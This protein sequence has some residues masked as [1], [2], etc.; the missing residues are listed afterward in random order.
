MTNLRTKVASLP[1]KPIFQRLPGTWLLCM[2]PFAFL[3]PVHT[4]LAFGLYYFI[5]H[6][7][8]LTNNARSAYGMYVAYTNAKLYSVTDWLAKYTRDTGT[9][10]GHDTR[11]DL[12]YEHVMHVIIL[13]NYKEELDTLYETLDVLASHSRAVSQYKICLAMEE[14][15]Q[16]SAEKAQGLMAQY[17]DAF[18]EI[19]Y[20][21]HPIGREGEIRGKSSNVAWASSQMAQR[22]GGGLAGRHDHEIITV[23]DAD[24]CF[25]SDYF[26]AVTYHYTT[27]SPAQRRIM[28]FAPCTVFDRNSNNVPVFVRVTDMFWSIGVISNLYPSSAIK[29]PCSAYSVSMDLALG[30]NFWDAGPEAIGE[31]MH[32]YLKC[33]F[34]TQGKVIVKSIFS[35]ASQCNV[36]G[37]GKGGIHGYA[38]GMNARYDQAKRHLWGSLDTGYV[39][40]RTLINALNPESDPLNAGTRRLQQSTDTNAKSNAAKEVTQKTGFRPILMLELVHRLLESHILMGHLFTLIIVSAL[41]LPIR[42]SFSYPIATFFWGYLS[43]DPVH[44]YVE[45][46]LNVSFWVRMVI[47]VPNVIMIWYYEQYHQWVGFER[48]AL[49]PTSAPT[50]VNV[51]TPYPAHRVDSA[52]DLSSDLSHP[53]PINNSGP[54][55]QHLGKRSQLSSRRSFPVNLLDWFTIP[56]AGFCF[57]VLPQFHA[58]ISHLFTDRLDYKVAAKP[59]LAPHQH[60]AHGPAEPLLPIINNIPM[61]SVPLASVVSN[62]GRQVP[63][64][65]NT[66][67]PYRLLLAEKLNGFTNVPPAPVSVP[68]THA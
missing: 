51:K 19:T 1:W 38:S 37:N 66:M 58:Q 31:D 21:I 4:P 50:S 46:A 5:L 23:M 14:S 63:V 36:E 47:V 6:L 52:L 18:Y 57:Y 12:P 35:P 20:T 28:M 56:V 59:T 55:V 22:S 65:A 34:A 3:G 45:L 27:A 33:F 68:Y 15:E 24:T 49:Q 9:T 40:R 62:V 25:A 17:A 30:V 41:I 10:D 16:G 8:F 32:M 2:L 11:H 54:Q 42:S 44:P 39:L 43:S 60:H 13:P 67:D 48:W 29:I 7:A 61:E 53:S 26:S 64:T